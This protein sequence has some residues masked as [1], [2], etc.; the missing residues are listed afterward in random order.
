MG[1]VISVFSK[2]YQHIYTIVH[3]ECCQHFVSIQLR[4]LSQC[5]ILIESAMFDATSNQVTRVGQP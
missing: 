4:A 2:W 3:V 5:L 1:S